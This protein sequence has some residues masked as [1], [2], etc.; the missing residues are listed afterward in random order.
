MDPSDSRSLGRRAFLRGAGAVAAGLG[1]SG[2]ALAQP[3]AAKPMRGLYPIG[4]TPFTPDNKIDLDCLAAEV[5]F[6]N[7]GGVPGFIWPQIASG[8]STMSEP[9]RLSGAEAILSAGKGGKTS[10]V[11]G[12]QSIGNDLATSVRYAQHAARHGADAIVSLPPDK[13]DD[14]AM[15]DYYKAIGAAT[16]LPLIVQSQGNMSVDLIVRLADQIP[17]VVCVKD[18]AGDPLARIADIRARTHDRIAVFAGKGVRNMLDELELGFTG[19][20]PTPGLADVFQQAADL[21]R[22]GHKREAF[23]MFGRVEAF[24]TIAGSGQ[25]LMVA[26]G[27]FKDTT[28][29]R[30]TPGMGGHEAPITQAQKVFVRE[31]LDQF[32]KPYLRA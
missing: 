18:E 8:W 15:L 28:T 3:P 26:R 17:T 20:C 6:C 29:Y 12:V 27:V 23:D 1:L 11:I 4:Q 14:Q 2:S 13:A 10:L 9:E 24:Q 16:D 22:A 30:P 7:R 19:F 31:A 32:L 21:W 25:Y 5:N